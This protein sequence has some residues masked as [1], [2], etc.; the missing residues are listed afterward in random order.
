MSFL[1]SLMLFGGAAVAIPII[2]H[3]L[4]R[5]KFRTITWAAMKFV[6]LSV[7][8][9]QRRIR[10]EDLILLLIRCAILAL[11]AFALA[12]PVMK[13]SRT[14][15]LGQAKVTGVIVLDNSYSMDLLGEDGNA[16]AFEQ[17]RAAAKA[18]LDAMPTGS[19]VAVLLAS[20]VVQGVI[21]EPTHDL[22][23]AREVIERAKVSDHATDL[24]PAMVRAMEILEGRAVLRKEIYL[25]T[26][27]QASG[28][29]QRT[30]IQKLIAKNQDDIDVYV[31]R[32]GDGKPARNWAITKIDNYD[33]LTPVGHPLRFEVVVS[34]NDDQVAEDVA[35]SLY[36]GTD[37]NAVDTITVPT[38]PARGTTAVTL[39]AS[40]KQPGHHE[41]RA[42]FPNPTQADGLGK[43]NQ[44]RLV[45]NAVEKVRVLM[46]HDEDA[47]RTLEDPEHECYFLNIA[48]APVSEHYVEVV[49]KPSA[50]FLEG[51]LDRYTAVILAN[52]RQISDDQ[53]KALKSYLQQGG[54]VIFFPGDRV[55]LNF[56]N[57]QLFKEHGLL[58]SPWGDATGDPAQDEQFVEFQKRD[59]EHPVTGLWNNPKY[60]G[61]GMS[62]TFCMLP[63][64][65]HASAAQP[66]LKEAGPAMVVLRFTSGLSK[67]GD[68]TKASSATPPAIMERQWGGGLVYQFSST[69][70]KDW[71][72]LPIRGS[73][74]ILMHRIVG[75]VQARQ[76]AG[77]NLRVGEP[78]IHPLDPLRS[79]Q[80]GFVL[81]SNQTNSLTAAQLNDQPVLRFE[82]THHAGVYQF[83][84]KG[85]TDGTIFVVQH[86]ARESDLR[87][88]ADADLPVPAGSIIHWDPKGD[89]A[90]KVKQ[91][92]VG[93]EYWLLILLVVL[94]LVGLETYLAQKF[95]HSK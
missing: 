60:T 86:D 94:A 26:D 77:L 39:Y 55:D 93:A 18:T 83:Q 34:N 11:L 74:M 21:D 47:T 43:D 70:D 56:Y 14:D 13:S 45:V 16:T 75:S 85:E 54:G 48:L 62:R 57:D 51:G 73:S 31:L 27:G 49:D 24:Y 44:N 9:N 91:A 32:V 81:F 10:L 6:Q 37:S 92:R 52:V 36:V 80:E 2:I 38:V 19:R 63:M 29:Q 12:R 42:A 15:V 4:N 33:G 69:A 5:R 67:G 41:I 1:N 71:S 84:L 58:P 46:V 66:T 89:F 7:E 61:L 78:F 23:Q 87:K 30:D 82:D 53:I 17:A 95:S 25:I 50:G 72:D 20:D 90:A 65:E 8:Q 79:D 68:K 59:F 40:L 64:N 22:N 28:W 76:D 35:V 88:I 3:F